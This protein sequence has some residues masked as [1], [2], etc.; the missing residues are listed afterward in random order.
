MKY[1]IGSVALKHLFPDFPRNSKDIDYVVNEY[2]ENIFNENGIREE[3]HLIP[4]LYDYIS[5]YE[6]SKD[7]LY[8]LKISH[9]FWDIKWDKNM[10]DIVFLN[11]KGAKLIPS[12]FKDLYS[13]WN[14]EK[15]I[16]KR[17][18]LSKDGKDFFNNAL[19]KYD[20]DLLHTY[21]NPNPTYKKV[22]KDNAEVDVSEEK[23][24]LLLFE[25][26]LD[27]VREEIYVMAFERLADRDY[28]TAYKWMIQQFI[29]NHAPMFEALFII[30]NYK[31]LHLPKI[32]YKKI[33]ENK[34][35]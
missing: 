32:N 18:D 3:Y 33:L 6:I 1:I 25:E 30:E 35:K 19:K 8:T 11:E 24:N 21:I 10:F 26:K 29:M 9:I 23:F 15:G 27:L 4:P 2:H 12:L 34:L 31:I 22:L 13:F 7:V 14:K 20:H 17:T 16:N 28:R 5:K